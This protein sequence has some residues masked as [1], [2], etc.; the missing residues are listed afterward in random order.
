MLFRST[1]EVR[2]ILRD[3]LKYEFPTLAV[4]AYQELSP[5]LNIQPIARI[6]FS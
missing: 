2:A 3:L 5:N 1:I 4:L 6:S